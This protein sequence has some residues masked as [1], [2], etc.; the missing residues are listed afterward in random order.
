[1]AEFGF[2]LGDALIGFGVIARLDGEG[3]SVASSMLAV[4]N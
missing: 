1:M 3:M 4:V 2:T